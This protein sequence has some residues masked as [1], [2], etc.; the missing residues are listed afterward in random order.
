MSCSGR[1][2]DLLTLGRCPDTSVAGTVALLRQ[3]CRWLAP[4]L[5]SVA[6]DIPDGGPLTWAPVRLSIEGITFNLADP[7]AGVVV[8]GDYSARTRDCLVQLVRSNGYQVCTVHGAPSLSAAIRRSP[9][10]PSTCIHPLQAHH[11]C[12]KVST[13]VRSLPLGAS[14]WKDLLKRGF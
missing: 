2:G 3:L 12:S 8:V 6:T 1:E 11:I 9:A 13:L 4:S 7:T 14:Q 10:P 5:C